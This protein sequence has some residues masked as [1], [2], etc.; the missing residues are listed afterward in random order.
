ML[1]LSTCRPAAAAPA[2]ARPAT[3]MGASWDLGASGE[4]ERASGR[5]P[6]PSAPPPLCASLALPA[7]SL[8]IGTAALAPPAGGPPPRSAGAAPAGARDC[9]HAGH[10][11]ASGASA[12][13]ATDACASCARPLSRRPCEGTWLVQALGLLFSYKSASSYSTLL[14]PGT[15]QAAAWMG[16][17]PWCK[18]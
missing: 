1:C 10:G 12:S 6:Q 11:H 14:Q 5:P 3:A 18:T 4:Q 9:S 13:A 7:S 8:P 16:R 17:R 2:C 15:R